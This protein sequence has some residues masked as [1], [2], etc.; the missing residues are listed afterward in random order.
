MGVWTFVEVMFMKVT[1]SLIS[2]KVGDATNI[3]T[4]VYMKAP[5]TMITNKAKV[6]WNGQA[7]LITMVSGKTI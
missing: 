3:P 5:G 7:V 2:D 6:G 1:S 4:A